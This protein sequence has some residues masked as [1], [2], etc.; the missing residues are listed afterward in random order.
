MY[1]GYATSMVPPFVKE[2]VVNQ[3]IA[4]TGADY[5]K[6]TSLTESKSISNL[7]T[8]VNASPQV[9][10]FVPIRTRSNVVPRITPFG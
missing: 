6:A 4:R 5:T 3:H 8:L 9:I 1:C 10:L 2:R 7:P